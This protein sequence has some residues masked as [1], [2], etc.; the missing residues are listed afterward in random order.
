MKKTLPLI[1]FLL[2]AQPPLYAQNAHEDEHGEEETGVANVGPDSAVLEAD[3]DRGFRLSEK[4]RRTLDVEFKPA[5]G[6]L[7]KSSVVH[8]KDETGVYR[9][10]DGW[11]KLIEGEAEP[12]G[13]QVRFVPEH[14]GDLR[15]SDR[16]A[17]KGVPLLRVTE[18][19]VFSAG[20]GDPHGH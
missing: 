7:P 14:K 5:S 8:F 12:H 3:P 10:R 15:K 20:G 1:G 11:F 4:A 19:D 18:L 6:L 2:L 13:H 9:V 17:V 16:I